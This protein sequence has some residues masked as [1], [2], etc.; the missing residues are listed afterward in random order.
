MIKSVKAINAITYANPAPDCHAMYIAHLKVI[1]LQYTQPTTQL[2]KHTYIL[3]TV[4][5]CYRDICLHHR[6]PAPN[7]YLFPSSATFILHQTCD[8]VMVDV[9]HQ[10]DLESPPGSR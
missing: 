9:A 6:S 4:A 5:L 3:A 1:M 8:L 10:A 2:A 7:Q